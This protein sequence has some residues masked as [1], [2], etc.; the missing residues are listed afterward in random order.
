[1]GVLESLFHEKSDEV[2]G[3]SKLSSHYIN[4]YKI[5]RMFGNVANELD[6][7]VSLAS[8]H[9]VFYISMLK[10]CVGDHS[11]VVPIEDIGVKDSPSYE[12][13]FMKILD[14]QV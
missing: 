14:R 12:E 10:K 1:M 13:V 6:L 7:L 11:F 2:W 4:P 8:L 3:K 5:S 9:P